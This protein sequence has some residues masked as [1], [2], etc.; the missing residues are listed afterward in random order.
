M[1]ETP[2]QTLHDN[3][4]CTQTQTLTQEEKT[5][6][7]TIKRIP[8]FSQETKLEDSQVQNQESKWLIDKY[9][10]KWHQGV[11]WFNIQIKRLRQQARILKRNIKKVSDKTET[12]KAQWELN[13]SLRRPTKKY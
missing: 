3:D 4:S 13:K 10:D 2:N 6:V 1:P 9:P 11:K 12:E 7:D 5:N 8:A